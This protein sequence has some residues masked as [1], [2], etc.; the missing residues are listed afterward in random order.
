MA[1]IHTSRRSGFITRGGVKRRETL[2]I[3]D[4]VSETTLAGAPTAV[5]ISILSARGLALRPFTVVRCR[6]RIHLRS[7]QAVAAETYGAAVG[8]AVV[9]E[10]ASAIGVTAVP[11][12]ITDMSSDLW[13]MY[14]LMFS[15]LGINGAPA[16]VFEEGVGMDVDSRA[17]RKVE[18]GQDLA[19]VVENT[20][21]GVVISLAGRILLKL[22]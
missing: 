5:L 19:T 14:Q 11:T 3:D 2:W 4:P 8:L 7:D 10:Q 15:R 21:N 18:E 22:H 17:M 6:Y 12:P 20:I 1:N 16:T 13:L 9:S